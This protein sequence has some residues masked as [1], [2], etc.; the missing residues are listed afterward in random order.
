VAEPSSSGPSPDAATLAGLV[1]SGEASASEVV[2]AAFARIDALDDD[3]AAFCTLAREEASAA[4]R[5]I[6]RRRARGEKLGRL[7]GVPVAVKDLISTRGLRTTFGSPL[8]RS[9]VPDRDDIV[10]ERLRQA[11]A[12][13]VGKTNTSEFGYGPV[14]HNP[15]FATTRNPWNTALTPGGSSAGSAAA[16]ASGMVPFAIGSDGGGSI[17]IPAALSGIFGIKPSWGRVPVWPGCRDETM[18]GASGWES[19]EHIGPL[20]RTVGDAALLLSVVSGPSPKDRH[21][22][23]EEPLSFDR[24][25]RCAPAG[26][27]VAY[28]RDLGFALVEPEVA[29]IAED[30]AGVFESELGYCVETAAPAVGDMQDTFEA[31]VAL[32]TDRLGLGAIAA[33]QGYRFGGALARVLGTEWTADRFTGAIL[34]RKRIANLLWRFMER[35]DFLLTPTVSAAAFPIGRDGPA[36]IDGRAAPATAWTPFSALANLTGPPPLRSPQASPATA[37]RSAS[38]SSAAISTTPVCSRPRRPSKRPGRGAR[39]GRRSSQPGLRPDPGA[40]RLSGK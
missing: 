33:G 10:V 1:A 27:R 35:Y 29:E 32:D 28:S 8:Y 38:R 22:L 17:R 20:S 5:D 9:F 24:R 34:A 39:H 19:L 36:E 15:L 12:V 25:G 2:A 11:D 7:A 3:I 18:P 23:P 40:A 14:G 6:D 26:A 37:V 31:L 4:A 30:A 13:I 16:V 21:S